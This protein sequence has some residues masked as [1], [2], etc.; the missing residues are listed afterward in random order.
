VKAWPEKTL[1]PQQGIL[2][3]DLKPSNVL[4]DQFDRPRVTDF[5]LAK[6]LN[7]G[8][9][10]GLPPAGFQYATNVR[11]TVGE[12]LAKAGETPGLLSSD[13]TATGQVLGTPLE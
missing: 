8:Q 12:M 2:H 3:R 13:L 7:V 6:R 9:A 10:S 5:G 4:I 11:S 1:S